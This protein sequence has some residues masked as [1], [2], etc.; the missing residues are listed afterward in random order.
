MLYPVKGLVG[1]KKGCLMNRVALRR[2]MDFLLAVPFGRGLPE[3]LFAVSLISFVEVRQLSALE[4]CGDALR[5][6][7]KVVEQLLFCR[8]GLFSVF[9]GTIIDSDYP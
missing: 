2:K 8:G 5:G 1:N 4:L 7:S 9:R 6:L 3:K